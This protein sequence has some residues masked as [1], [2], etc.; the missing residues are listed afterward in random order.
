MVFQGTAATNRARAN[1][2]KR[3]LAPPTARGKRALENAQMYYTSVDST[4]NFLKDGGKALHQL[5]QPGVSGDILTGLVW[6]MGVASAVSYANDLF[7][8]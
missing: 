5:V 4:R 2:G 6:G 3:A 7:E 1:T 8:D